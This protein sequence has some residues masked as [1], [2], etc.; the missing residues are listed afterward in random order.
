MSLFVLLVCPG[1]RESQDT[2]VLGRRLCTFGRGPRDWLR[3]GTGHAFRR[4]VGRAQDGQ[5]M[6]E[7]R[8]R[9]RVY[10]ILVTDRPTLNCKVNERH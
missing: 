4:W 1:H 5:A 10:T 7:G 8:G 2:A 3:W 6:R 9:T